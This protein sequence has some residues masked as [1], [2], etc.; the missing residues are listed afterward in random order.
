M[1]SAASL[2]RVHE[3]PAEDVLKS[4]NGDHFVKAHRQKGILPEIL[5]ELL[6]ARKRAKT[7][8]KAATDPFMKAVLDGR[9]LAL[10]VCC[11]APPYKSLDSGQPA[12][13]GQGA[14]QWLL[15]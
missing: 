15:Q 8:L 2:C 5:E 10:K 3:V 11:S 12:C 14:A 1:T 7:D 6:S 9:Q 13:I 4:P